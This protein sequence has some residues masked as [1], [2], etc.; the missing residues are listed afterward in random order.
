ML[1]LAFDGDKYVSN[2][3]NGS[4]GTQNME[5]GSISNYNNYNNPM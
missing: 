2:Q 4:L 5:N 3:D 1:I